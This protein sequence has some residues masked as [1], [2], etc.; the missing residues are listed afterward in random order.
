MSR[1]GDRL[2]VALAPSPRALQDTAPWLPF[3]RGWGDQ[4]VAKGRA[5]LAL[6]LEGIGLAGNIF[7]LFRSFPALPQHILTAPARYFCFEQKSWGCW[8][9]AVGMVWDRAP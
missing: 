4:A 2:Q 6:N 9:G 5:T 3:C 8:W 1:S 7:W